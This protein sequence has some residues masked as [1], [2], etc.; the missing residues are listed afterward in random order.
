M[1]FGHA[2]G[3]QDRLLAGLD[4]LERNR[5]GALRKLALDGLARGVEEA[6]TDLT[7]RTARHKV[8][9]HAG[10]QVTALEERARLRRGA[11]TE[12]HHIGMTAR[13]EGAGYHRVAAHR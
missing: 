5:N 9:E 12:D 8:V 11:D 1:M 7:H 10:I 6:A 13:V 4:V 2:A 3:D